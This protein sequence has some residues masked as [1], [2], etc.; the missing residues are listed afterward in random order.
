[1][2]GAGRVVEG[3]GSGVGSR[4]WWRDKGCRIELV[5]ERAGGKELLTGAVREQTP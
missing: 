5:V 2:G 3:A 1:M 4:R